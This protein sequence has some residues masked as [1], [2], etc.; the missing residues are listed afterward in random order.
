[1]A[2]TYYERLGVSADATTAE[3]E[4]AYRD[5]L[6]ETHPDVSDDPAAAER[7]RA[8]I[9]AKRVLSDA[10][11][12][13]RYDRLGHRAY[14]GEGEETAEPRP[15]GR[16]GSTADPSRSTDRSDGQS[17][18]EHQGAATAWNRSASTPGSSTTT[19]GGQADRERRR[20]QNRETRAAWNTTGGVADGGVYAN[21]W[22]AWDTDGAYRIHGTDDTRLGSRLFP[23]GPSLV[24]LLVTF[25][26]YPVLLWGALEPAFPIAFNLVLGGCLLFL[27]AFLASMPPVGAAVF[28]T[29]TLLLPALLAFGGVPLSSPL[30]PIAI[31]GTGLPLVLVLVVWAVLR[32]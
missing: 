26:V 20:R 10:D 17:P 3:I 29:W 21:E 31:L 8:L 24:V 14:V 28:G 22:R 2:E 15:D 23:V 9:E 13:A 5:R 19:R 30:W 16:S 32:A 11:E 1:M 18:R 25:A 12:R 6:K 7:T 4:A 27:V